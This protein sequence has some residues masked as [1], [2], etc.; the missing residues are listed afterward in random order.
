M[1][2]VRFV[3]CCSAAALLVAGCVT[4]DAGALMREEPKIDRVFFAQHHVLE[5]ESPLFKLVG[6]LDALIKVQVYSETPV[7]SPYVAA[8]LE[9]GGRTA[10]IS[11]TG[12][13]VLPRK[14][15][16]DPVLMEQSY[17]NSFTAVI[18]KEWVKKGLSVTQ[19]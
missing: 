8:R 4:N 11:L 18:S 19:K 3:I 15:A 2:R 16:C 10:E 13:K 17:S 9:L 7:S 5:P 1:K 14:Q 6:N 12:P